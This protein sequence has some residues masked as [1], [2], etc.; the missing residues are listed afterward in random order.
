[1]FVL[2]IVLHREVQD[3]A[4]REID[5]VIGRDRLPNFDDRCRLPYVERVVQETF[6]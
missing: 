1:M 6:R 4:G 2:C 5:E 3:E